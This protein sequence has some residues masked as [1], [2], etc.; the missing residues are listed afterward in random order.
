VGYGLVYFSP[1]YDSGVHERIVKLLDDVWRVHGVPWREV[2]VSY[3]DWYGKPVDVSEE[4][5]YERY[6]RPARGTITRCLLA[7]K[8]AGVEVFVERVSR[9]FRTRSGDYVV[10][11]SVAL[12]YNDNIIC[13]LHYEKEITA[14][15]SR[16]L[17]GGVE[18]LERIRRWED[19]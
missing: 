8:E 13:A 7:L 2:V 1:Y 9:K 17:E 3:Y 5:V 14:F 15:L 12:T 16:L 18:F 4:V 6:L 10:A 19:R 11:G